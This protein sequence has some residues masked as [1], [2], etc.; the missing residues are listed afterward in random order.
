MNIL[1]KEKAEKKQQCL[2]LTYF[3]TYKL[4]KVFQTF[5]SLY[6]PNFLYG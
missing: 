4:F 3:I 2:N 6:L 5:K 1:K